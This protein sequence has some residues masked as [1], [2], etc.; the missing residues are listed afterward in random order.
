MK[1]LTFSNFLLFISAL[2][3]DQ[4]SKYMIRLYG[5]FY[6]CN[7]NISFSLVLPTFLFWFIWALI[8][9]FIF[10]RILD[11]PFSVFQFPVAKPALLL[12]LAGALSNM[13]DR[14]YFGCIIDFIKLPYWPVFNLADAFIVISGIISLHY[15]LKRNY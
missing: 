6:I 7:Q 10:L 2:F 9:L 13:L 5:G 4:I 1:N 11:F 15:I 12:L 14:L 3:L 8:V